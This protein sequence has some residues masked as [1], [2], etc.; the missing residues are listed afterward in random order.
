M[1]PAIALNPSMEQILLKSLQQA[2]QSGNTDDMML[3]PGMAERLQMALQE[4]SEKQE[5]AGKPSVLLVSA[6]L[7]GMLAKFIRYSAANMN[8]L[9]YNEIPDDKQITI[10]STVG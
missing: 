4:A 2:Q 6:P 1:L 9:S 5:L 8:V 10:E 7:R 3:E